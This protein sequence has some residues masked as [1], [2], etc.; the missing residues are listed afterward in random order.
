MTSTNTSYIQHLNAF[1]E[2]SQRDKN[3]TG[4]HISLYLALFS[5]WNQCYFSNPFKFSR[6]KVLSIS[7]IGSCNTY[8]KC[9]KDLADHGYIRYFPSKGNGE[10]SAVSIVPLP[11]STRRKSD[12]LP[13]ADPISNDVISAPTVDAN[14]RHITNNTNSIDK[15][16]G[17]APPPAEKISKPDSLKD[18]VVFFHLLG[19][20]EKEAAKFFHH[21]EANG[22]RQ[23]G[24]IPI[25]NWPAAARKWILNIHPTQTA[26]NDKRGK[27]GN[28]HTNQDKGYS[29]PL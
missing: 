1:I 9:M 25:T 3:L 27:P 22:W 4:N 14:M 2:I 28:L 8:S 7:H 26:K 16:R 13:G 15:E 5:I 10:Q 21:Y 23:A 11:Q 19:H 12:P 18:V 17:N 20:S 24:K 29:D 6:K